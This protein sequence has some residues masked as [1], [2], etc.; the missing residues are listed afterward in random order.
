MTLLVAGTLVVAQLCYNADA[1][2]GAKDFLKQAQI[3]NAQLTAMSEARESGC[4]EIRSE[5][6]MEEAKRLVKSD[7]TQETL[8]IE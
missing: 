4:V 5:N 7:S 1:D 8:T 3:F 6:A 2:I